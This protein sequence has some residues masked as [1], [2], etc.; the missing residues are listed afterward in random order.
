MASDS[1]APARYDGFDRM[2][3][4]GTWG[5]GSSGNTATD[6]DPYTGEPLTEIRLADAGDLD[7]AYAAARDAQGDWAGRLPAERAAV[8][9]RGTGTEAPTTRTAPP[10]SSSPSR[11]RRRRRS[12]ARARR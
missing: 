8:M 11:A 9:R 5:P 12:W 6:T 7:A 4:A 3:I 10:C 2:P 1:S